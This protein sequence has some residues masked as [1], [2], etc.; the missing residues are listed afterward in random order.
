MDSVIASWLPLGFLEAVAAMP[1][2]ELAVPVVI[3]VLTASIMTFSIPG[4]LTPTAFFSG[5]LMGFGG[6]LVVALGAVIG[7]H[8][9]LLASRRWLSGSMQRRFGTR[10]DGVRDHLEKRGPIYVAG[11]RLSGVPHVLITAGCA[12][13]P[14]S[15]RSFAG[16]TLLGLMPAIVLAVGA[17]S[18]I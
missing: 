3:A 8:I 18:A 5:M 13:A 9:L 11:A 15:G 2:G 14:I 6:I 12:A 7:S 10:L 1:Y 4:A 17:G 16:A